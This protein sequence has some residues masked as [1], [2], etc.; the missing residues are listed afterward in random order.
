MQWDAWGAMIVYTFCTIAFYLLGAAFS[1][2]PGV[3]EKSDSSRPSRQCMNRSLALRR[4]A[5]FYLV[6]LPLFSTFF[7]ASPR[8]HA[9]PRRGQRARPSQTGRG[10]KEKSCERLG[11]PSA[12]RD[13]LRLLSPAIWLILTAGTMQAILLQ[14]WGFRAFFSAIKKVTHDSVPAR[15][16][17]HAL[18][19]VPRLSRD[20]CAPGL[21]KTLH[22][23]SMRYH[24]SNFLPRPGCYWYR[25]PMFLLSAQGCATW[26]EKLDQ[27]S[28]WKKFREESNQSPTLPFQKWPREK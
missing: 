18:A 7:V 11:W 12:L 16:G 5:S 14:C 26:E 28:K 10:S 22:L 27:R 2:V 21:H 24:R 15:F 17:S 8:S 19:L 20:R 23:K 6:H 13:H 9:W 3:P 4:K 25:P 1:G